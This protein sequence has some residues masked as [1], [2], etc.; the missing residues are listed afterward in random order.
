MRGRGMG[1]DCIAC[2]APLCSAL[3]CY[4]PQSQ[5]GKRLQV[6]TP[7]AVRSSPRHD[8]GARRHGPPRA[9]ARV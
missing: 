3:E 2:S 1:S 7:V 6:R 4:A 8:R 5:G 9:H